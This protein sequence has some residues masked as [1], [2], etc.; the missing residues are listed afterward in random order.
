MKSIPALFLFLFLA[1]L[2]IPTRQSPVVASSTY[3]RQ[4]PVNEARMNLYG[5]LNPDPALVHQFTRGLTSDYHD[6]LQNKAKYLVTQ[7][8]STTKL[9]LAH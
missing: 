8:L 1:V 3:L 9:D 4:S 2:C 7:G 6:M 5:A